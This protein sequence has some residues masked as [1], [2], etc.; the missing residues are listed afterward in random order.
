MV[1][2]LELF[3]RLLYM[4]YVLSHWNMARASALFRRRL[5]LQLW[6]DSA[7]QREL[8]LASNFSLQRGGLSRVQNVQILFPSCQ[9]YGA[10]MKEMRFMFSRRRL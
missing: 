10:D 1:S 3:L 8:I 2:A 5:L 4:K 7:R 9:T 6:S